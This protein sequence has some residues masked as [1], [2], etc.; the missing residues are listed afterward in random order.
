[1]ATLDITVYRVSMIRK[2]KQRKLSADGSDII[3]KEFKFKIS[4]PQSIYFMLF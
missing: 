1:M 3:V 4:S 2:W